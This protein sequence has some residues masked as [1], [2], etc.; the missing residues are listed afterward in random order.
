MLLLFLAACDQGTPPV[1]AGT[2]HGQVTVEGQGIDGVT[3]ALS[4]GTSTTTASGGLF[5]FTDVDNGTYTVT[6]SNFPVDVSFTSTFLPATITTG[7]LRATLNFS[8]T[9]IRTASIIG[10][11]T[12]D[13]SGLDGVT[14][15]LSG[16]SDASTQT[17]AD[18]LYTF[19]QLRAGSYDVEISGFAADVIFSN[20]TRSIAVGVGEAERISFN[21][22]Y[23]RSA[24]IVGSVTADR[25]GVEAV[26]V[27]LTGMEDDS[28][29]TDANGQFTFTQL[30]AGSYDVEISS[31]AADL[32]FSS[33]TRNVTVGVGEEGMISFNGWYI[34]TASILG[35]VTVERAGLSGVTV[36][37]S[38]MSDASTQTD[39]NGQFAFTTLRAGSYKLELSGFA[40]DVIFSAPAQNVTLGVGETETTTFEGTY[41]RTAAIQGRVAVEGQGLSGVTVNLSGVGPARIAT[42]DAAGQY[43]FNELRAGVYQVGISGFS[44]DDYEFS[45]TSQSVTVA[46]GQTAN[47]PFDG[48]RLR[49]AGISGQVAAAGQ[50]IGGVIVA[51]SGSATAKD[52]TNA[53]GQYGFPGLE[54]GT[55]TVTISGWDSL[56]Y[57]FDTTSQ[58]VQLADNQAAIASFIG[59]RVASNSTRQALSP[60]GSSLTNVASDAGRLA[61]L[62]PS[63][64]AVTPAGLPV[65]PPHILINH[66]P[67]SRLPA[68]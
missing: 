11:V 62:P 18:G 56:R 38:G 63:A 5:L 46:L 28:T 8:G 12:V 23:A 29:R 9:Y 4:T 54:A 52:T 19:T 37:L 53:Q 42:T 41:V 64:A 16:R 55:Y 35:S 14:V 22:M 30:R 49:T 6:I 25:S 45:Q 21:G 44:A 47:V 65:A 10:S 3:V 13:G 50:G 20:T 57:F 36:R 68:P 26:K 58:T 2:I 34:R 51:L 31:F 15:A 66:V 32:I 59:V 7:G 39:S 17:D 27:R 48:T 1:P 61:G 43:A 24:S 67:Q 60:F 40:A 33:T